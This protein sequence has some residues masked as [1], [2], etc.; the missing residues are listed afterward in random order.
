MSF[1]FITRSVSHTICIH[2]H[3]LNWPLFIFGSEFYEGCFI[4]GV[5]DGVDHGHPACDRQTIH[6]R[7]HR[8]HGWGDHDEKGWYLIGMTS[9]GK[10]DDVDFK[11]AFKLHL[12]ELCHLPRASLETSWTHTAGFIPPF[13][14]QKGFNIFTTSPEQMNSK[15]SGSIPVTN[16]VTKITHS[17]RFGIDHQERH[18]QVCGSAG[19]RHCPPW[20]CSHQDERQRACLSQVLPGETFFV[21]QVGGYWAGICI[22]VVRLGRHRPPWCCSH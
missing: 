13:P 5:C 1:A 9:N 14:S 10:V 19:P 20:C 22:L 15:C 8:L 16:W 6:W 11:N 7:P 21:Y 3:S 12:D 2:F 17:W 18:E 4:A